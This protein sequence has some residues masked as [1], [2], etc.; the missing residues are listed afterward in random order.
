MP[1]LFT[2]LLAGAASPAPPLPPFAWTDNLLYRFS[3]AEGVC[4]DRDGTPA[5]DGDPVARWINLGAAEDAV[6]P[7]PAHRPLWRASGIGGRPAVVCDAGLAQHFA[8]LAF[9]QPSGLGTIRPWT[10]FA[11]T[12]GVGQ[13]DLFP[14]LLGSTAANGGKM[15]LYF[16]AEAGAQIH[17]VKAQAR[18]GTLANPQLLMCAAGRSAKAGF[19]TFPG[20]RLWIRQNRVG[21][22]E[23]D[24]ISGNLVSTAIATTQFLRCTGLSTDGHFHGRLH[25]ILMFDGTL[26]EETT[27]AVEDWLAAA[28]GLM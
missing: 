7:D 19:T 11:V 13:L 17:F 9:D 16:R 12:D 6:Q 8:D 4:R 27:F 5:A 21:V 15:G 1:L 25:E 23:G 20:N 18:T 14:A 2:S 22:W 10:V 28:H 3:A 26:D 24:S